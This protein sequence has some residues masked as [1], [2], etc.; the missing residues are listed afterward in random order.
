MGGM[1]KVNLVNSPI[2]TSPVKFTFKP[3]KNNLLK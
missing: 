1:L 2:Q 3:K